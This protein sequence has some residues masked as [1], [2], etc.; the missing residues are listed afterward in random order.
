MEGSQLCTNK[1]CQVP[2]AAH[3]QLDACTGVQWPLSQMPAARTRRQARIAHAHTQTARA[4]TQVHIAHAHTQMPTAL[5]HTQVCMSRA[6]KEGRSGRARA[7]AFMAL[8]VRGPQQVLVR[9]ALS[10]PACTT[11]C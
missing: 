4:H 8:A 6:H 7:L 10:R 2:C 11:A 3:V 1:V 9:V 5:A